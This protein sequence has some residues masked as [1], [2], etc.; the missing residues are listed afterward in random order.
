MLRRLWILLLALM[1][2]AVSAQTSA[3]Q[4]SVD[5]ALLVAD[6]VVVTP[7]QRLIADGN[8]EALYNGT[9]L[10]AKRIIYISD[11][12]R[13][14]IQGPIR[15]D[16]GQGIVVLADSADLDT[17]L[18]NGLLKGARL[19][20]DQQ[21]QLASVQMARVEGRYAQL[22]KVTV[23]SC[24]ICGKNGR[25]LWS[26]RARRVVHDQEE[27]QLYFDGAV[28]RVLDVPLMYL[29]R[30]RL[31]DPTLK[32]A[33]GL[34][35]PTIR[36]TTELG[37][38]IKLPYFIPLGDHADITVT[39]YF[40]QE[41]S[42]VELRYRQAFRLGDI[43]L[44]GAITRDTLRRDETRAYL[45]GEGQFDLRDNYILSFDFE[46]TSDESYLSEYDYS[47]KDRLDSE[48]SLGRSTRESDM[49]A[50]LVLFN[51][52][53][54]DELNS[55]QPTIIPDLRYEQRYQLDNALGGE[56]RLAF[57]G[58]GHVRYSSNDVVGRDVTRAGVSA[59]WLDQ[60]TF[61][62][63]VQLAAQAGVAFDQFWTGDDSTVASTDS[64]LTPSAA[65]T[66]RYPFLRI[67]AG[68][69]RQ[70]IEPVAQIGWVG[71]EDA[72]VANDEST[73]QELDEGNLLALSRFPEADRRERGS[74]T[75]LG[76]RFVH[77]DPRGWSGGL[78]LGRVLRT[79]TLDDFTATS[80]LNLAESDWLIAAHLRNVDGLY[81]L[82]RT[83]VGDNGE[84]SK[85]EARGA[86]SNDTIDLGASFLLLPADSEEDRADKVAEWSI[87]G[88]YRVNRHWTASASASYDI[89]DKR[90]S[91]AGLGLAYRNECIEAAFTAE[92]KFADS[93]NLD[94][95]TTY[96]LT[97][98]LKGFSTGG[99]AGGYSRTCKQ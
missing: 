98:A 5:P 85:S 57:E 89:V 43:E 10:W 27:Q 47:G 72:D 35:F 71:G 6:T 51:T 30:L 87:D 70:L 53:R 90:A 33:H 80:G 50:S 21:L 74:S 67:T 25:A 91:E 66:L 14:E 41:T 42:T 36:T 4:G 3:D 83:L 61:A 55:T 40:S 48:L 86:W 11:A 60:W 37:T 29:P 96:G 77:H 38:G 93:S 78:A 73:R 45:F 88:A 92:R 1:P 15:I 49:Q 84:V 9:R 99:D 7:D 54:D 58:H 23:T 69:A 97:I 16:D 44:N 63:G 31:P 65:V 26:I 22:S 19:V 20:L 2:L 39:P 94:P 68:G 82:S 81:I 46:V 28:F 56:L 95:S 18:E 24:Q 52:L 8:V 62:S 75:V 13:L 34:L 59:T 64:S 12:D 32:R 79:D 76:L 17:N